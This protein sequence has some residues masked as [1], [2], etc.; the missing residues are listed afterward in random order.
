MKMSAP[1]ARAQARMRA[2]RISLASCGLS[3]PKTDWNNYLLRGRCGVAP[4]HQDLGEE[5]IIVCKMSRGRRRGDSGGTA[6]QAQVVVWGGRLAGV[7]QE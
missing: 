3:A 6:R 4:P 5:T 2:T 1:G 7:S